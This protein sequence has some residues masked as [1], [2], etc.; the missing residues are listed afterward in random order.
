MAEEKGK[1][2]VVV[3]GGISGLTTA[4]EAA[5]VGYEVAL[6]EKNPY[7]GGRVTQLNKYFPKL[8]PPNCGLEI[9]FRRI[10]N[11]PRV[12][13]YTLAEVEKV[14]GSEGDF[15]VS[16][17]LNPRYVNDNC[18]GC[19]ACV[20]V[21]P[22]ER[23]N[24]FNFGM[25]KTK[26]IYFPHEF[27]FPVKYVIDDKVCKKEECAKCVS[28]CTY[29]AIDLKMQPKVITLKAGSI[30]WATGWNPY[31]ATKMD[32]LGF[33]KYSNVITNMMMERLA[34]MT[35]PTNGKILRPSDGKEVKKIA[36][37][38]CAGSRDENHLAYCSF[39]CCL[40]S[41]KQ[42]TYMREQYPESEVI[43]F[44][45]DIRAPGRNEKFYKKVQK[46]GKIRFIKG[47]VAQIEE[48]P[49]TKELTVIAEDAV[50]G[51][52]I[53]EKVEMVVL[54]TGMSPVTRDAKVPAGVSY[55]EDGFI[56]S[57]SNGDGMYAAGCARKPF[58]VYSTVQDST[59]AALKA[60][61]SLVRR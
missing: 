38:Q 3:G 41:M 1:S 42:A 52:K 10:K 40:A 7:L 4:V 55:D 60:I 18:T 16:V 37:V 51:K 5:E 14:S 31:D 12:K 45:I 13:V 36:F 30:V 11:N 15:E 25:D 8:C 47:K 27:A 24:D 39:I 29:K 35:G 26:A 34:N 61:Q 53:H 49:Q 19:N 6:I 57:G 2:I 33:G 44:Y 17:K 48:D 20:D 56:I 58:D 21:C 23:S 22:V 54:A 9:N 28:A 43:I 46:D 32:N 59:A 50:A